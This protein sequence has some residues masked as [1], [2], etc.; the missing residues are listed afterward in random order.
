M[1]QSQ[2]LRPPSW[3]RKKAR[4]AR[5]A[6]AAPRKAKNQRRQ[7]QEKFLRAR[8]SSR[9]QAAKITARRGRAVYLY[10]KAAAARKPAKSHWP[11]WQPYRRL[12]M[13]TARVARRGRSM[14]ISVVEVN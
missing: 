1:V 12:R 8:H 3:A 11:L 14:N 5:E 9:D 2:R 10:Q 13:Y 6:A 7:S 4:M